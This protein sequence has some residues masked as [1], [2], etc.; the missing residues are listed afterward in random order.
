[1]LGILSA[2]ALL[3]VIVAFSGITDGWVING[4]DQ[5]WVAYLFSVAAF[6]LIPAFAWV[7]DNEP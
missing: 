3:L 2:M 5:S 4:A 6:T 1:M 7:L